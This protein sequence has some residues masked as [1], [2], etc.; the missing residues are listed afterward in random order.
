MLLREKVVQKIRELGHPGASEFFGV[1][2]LLI[3]QWEKGSKPVSL[4]AVEKVFELPPAGEVITDANWEGKRV[5]LCLPWYAGVSPHTAVSVMGLYERPKMGVL[6]NAGNSFIAHSRNQ[7]ATQFLKSGVEWSMWFDS[8]MIF[9]TGNAAWFNS[10]TGFNLPDKFAGV[11]TINR[12][13]GH[14][15]TL[16]G[17]MYFQRQDTGKPCY[18]EGCDSA[19]ERVRARRGPRDEVR[20]MKWVGTGCLLVHRDVFLSIAAK[21]PKLNGFWFSHGDESLLHLGEDVLFCQRAAAA[22]HTPHVDLGLVCGHAGQK[23]F[24]PFNTHD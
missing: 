9:P 13:M 19:G 22:G 16:V 10:V 21:N 23:I 2:E 1:S 17:G 15:K 14:G 3:S 11:H 7:I 12:L 18:S 20:P 6:L 8:D 24:G 4:A 5:M